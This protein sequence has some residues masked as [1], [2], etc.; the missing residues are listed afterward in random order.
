M[1]RR[2]PVAVAAIALCLAA[3]AT[4]AAA[5]G[6]AQ[7]PPDLR[8]LLT[9]ERHLRL[10]GFLVRQSVVQARGGRAVLLSRLVERGRLAPARY[11]ITSS[12]AGRPVFLR[13]VGAYAYGTAP[14]LARLDGGHKWVRVRLR[15]LA[16]GRANVLGLI[17]SYLT[18]L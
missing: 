5:L 6:T 4:H 9:A 11:A 16:G 3:A 10:R 14:G 1:R 8:R 17:H 15:N 18:D 7:L 13:Y 12:V 2:F